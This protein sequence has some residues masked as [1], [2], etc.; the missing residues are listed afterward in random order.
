MNKFYPICIFLFFSFNCL[1]NLHA[2]EMKNHRI[3]K[4]PSDTLYKEHIDTSKPKQKDLYEIVGNLFHKTKKADTAKIKPIG[5]KPVF[6]FVP[7]VGYTLVSKLV[8]SITGNAAFRTD[9]QANISTISGNAGYTQNRQIVLPIE[10]E[11][12][13][14]HNTYE[15]VGDYR[16]YKYPQSTFGLGSN[17]NIANEDPLDYFYI[18]VYETLLR[19]ITGHFSA[20]AGYIIDYHT[21]ISE[22]GNLNGVKPTDYYLYGESGHSISS[23]ITFNAQFDSRDNSINPASGFYSSIQYRDNYRV[24]GS[25]TGWRSLVVD[26]RKYYKFPANSD[27]IIAFWSYDW[28]VLSGKPPYLDMPSTQWDTYSSTGR[29]YIQGRFRGAQ[30]VYFESEYRYKISANGLFGGVLFGNLQSFSGAPGTRLQSV[31]P[32]FGPGL[33]IKLNKVSKTNIA[34]DYGFGRQGSR[35]LFVNAGEIF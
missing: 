31:Q 17:S 10:S 15:L 22:R 21:N 2:Q 20:G 13:L 26:I 5:S 11:I 29:G 24:L 6:S 4:I 18:R 23:G 35:G 34:I 19:H 7:A 28:L 12:W 25:T 14:K 3:L 9:S 30:E 32:G 8:V 16:F 27:N 33:R 1:R